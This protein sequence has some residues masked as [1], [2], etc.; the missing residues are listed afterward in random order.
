[1]V[2]IFAPIDLDDYNLAI[3]VLVVIGEGNQFPLPRTVFYDIDFGRTVRVPAE[4]V[5]FLSV[6]ASTRP[7]S[8]VERHSHVSSGVAIFSQVIRMAETK[9][10]TNLVMDSTC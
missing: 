9:I 8:R 2:F 7:T 6:E 1:M 4:Q 10:V 3:L 5:M